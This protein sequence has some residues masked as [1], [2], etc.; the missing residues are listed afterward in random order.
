MTDHEKGGKSPL[1]YSVILASRQI[2]RTASS[3]F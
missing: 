1:F 3:H 2:R